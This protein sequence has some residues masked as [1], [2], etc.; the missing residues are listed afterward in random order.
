VHFSALLGTESAPVN[1]SVSG[2]GC[3]GRTCGTIPPFGGLYRT[4]QSTAPC[5]RNGDSNVSV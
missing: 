5:D 1:W 2:A 4:P 3:T